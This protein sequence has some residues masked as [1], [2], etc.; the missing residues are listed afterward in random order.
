MAREFC[1]SCEKLFDE[2]DCFRLNDSRWRCR[3]CVSVS[4]TEISDL[5]A[6]CRELSNQVDELVSDKERA[7]E[8]E[9]LVNHLPRTAMEQVVTDVV[10]PLYNPRYIDDVFVWTGR[11]NGEAKNED[12]SVTCPVSQCYMNLPAAK[13]AVA[14]KNMANAPCDD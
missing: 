5:R 2:A 4:V 14:Y 6:E 3:D 12:G 10:T 13:R 8:L 1:V 9:G 7:D 11:P